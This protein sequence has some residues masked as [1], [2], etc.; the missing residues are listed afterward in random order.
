MGS[1]SDRMVARSRLADGASHSVLV[2]AVPAGMALEAI[3]AVLDS[4]GVT[5]DLVSATVFPVGETRP[6]QIL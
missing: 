6:V 2:P 4:L 1:V 3:R 5:S